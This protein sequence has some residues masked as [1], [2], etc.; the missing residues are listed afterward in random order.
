ML[1]FQ[2]L[3]NRAS[4]THIYISFS[5]GF[6]SR[7]PSLAT[8]VLRLLLVIIFVDVDTLGTMMIDDYTAWHTSRIHVY[9]K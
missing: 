5:F 9:L 6:F 3:L 4:G 7:A 1:V 8:H 2:V